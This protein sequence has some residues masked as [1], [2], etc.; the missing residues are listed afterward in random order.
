MTDKK[1]C[2]LSVPCLSLCGI[3]VEPQASA[4]VTESARER[5]IALYKS[6][7]QDRNVPNCVVFC[8]MS[9]IV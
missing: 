2:T 8:P 9:Q 7:Q 5:R 6:Y 4:A 3:H 1:G